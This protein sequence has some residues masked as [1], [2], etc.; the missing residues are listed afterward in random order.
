MS[1]VDVSS[2]VDMLAAQTFESTFEV[3]VW[4]IVAR[5]GRQG[6]LDKASA[7]L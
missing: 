7:L 3:G 5:W 1:M 6:R 2:A 4:L